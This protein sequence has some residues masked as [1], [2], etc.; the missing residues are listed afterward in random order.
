MPAG[1]GGVEGN[2]AFFAVKRAVD[3]AE[4]TVRKQLQRRTFAGTRMP[5]V[6]DGIRLA[7]Q[8]AQNETRVV[9]E[10]IAVEA[11]GS[12]NVVAE[13]TICKHRAVGPRQTSVL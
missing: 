11:Y 10:G 9:A 3:G 5:D 4:F 13:Q 7:L 1:V 6:L 2:H 12:N 8:R